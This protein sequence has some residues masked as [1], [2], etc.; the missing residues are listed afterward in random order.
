MITRRYEKLDNNDVWNLHIT[1][2]KATGAF[3]KSGK[4]DEDL[5]NIERNY[6]KNRGEFLVGLIDERIVAMG[7]LRKIS[8]DV[9]EIKRMRV[10]PYYQRR[11]FGQ[12]IL[13]KLE[14]RAKELGYKAI[15]LDT[16]IKQIAAQNLYIKNGYSEIRREIE[17]WPLETIFY[18]KQLQK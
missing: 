12:E 8:N 5:N 3:S 17:G 16:T 11:G 10:H 7:A 1:A 13:E 9:A 6:L 15:Q 2:L 14:G 4:W 18:Q